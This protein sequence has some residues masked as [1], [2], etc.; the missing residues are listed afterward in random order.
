MGLAQ[1]QTMSRSAQTSASITQN[2]ELSILAAI[3]SGGPH[4]ERM[5]LRREINS[6]SE[7]DAGTFL[8]SVQRNMRRAWILSKKQNIFLKLQGTR[9][10]S[11]DFVEHVGCMVPFQS[12]FQSS[13]QSRFQYSFQFSFQFSFSPVYTLFL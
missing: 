9:W 2:L 1:Q 8:V 5:L 12:S 6:F 7:N 11:L 13:F 4:P 3:S 10:F